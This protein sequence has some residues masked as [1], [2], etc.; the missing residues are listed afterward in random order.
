MKFVLKSCLL[1]QLGIRTMN[2]FIYLHL[3]LDTLLLFRYE[4]LTYPI[5]LLLEELNIA[6]A[7]FLIYFLLTNIFFVGLSLFVVFCFSLT[8]SLFLLYFEE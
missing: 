3:L 8:K 7:D 4:F 2:D 1:D 5:F 6:F